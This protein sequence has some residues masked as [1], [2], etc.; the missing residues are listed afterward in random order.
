MRP[1]ALLVTLAALVMIFRV[2]WGVLRTLGLCAALGL[3]AA[4]VTTV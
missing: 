2:R 4:A 1:T 3:A